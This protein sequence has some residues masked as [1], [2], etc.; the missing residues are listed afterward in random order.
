MNRSHIRVK[1]QPPSPKSLNRQKPTGSWLFYAQR[2]YDPALRDDP[3]L[4]N[5]PAALRFHTFF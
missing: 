2:N 3:G 1:M 4:T 5:P